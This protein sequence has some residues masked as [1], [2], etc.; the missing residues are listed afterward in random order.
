V[1]FRLL[2][3]SVLLLNWVVLPMRSISE[4]S[5]VSS[6]EIAVWSLLVRVP[7]EAWTDSSRMR[8]RIE[9]T[10]FSAPSPVWIIEIPSWALRWAWA[11]PRV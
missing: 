1:L 4:A 7:F 10:S 2:S 3:S 11:R 9:W 8:C 6:V 5:W